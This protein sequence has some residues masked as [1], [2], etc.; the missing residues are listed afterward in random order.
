MNNKIIK[1]SL[2]FILFSTGCSNEKILEKENND[3]VNFP[4]DFYDIALNSVSGQPIVLTLKDATFLCSNEKG[5][6]EFNNNVNTIKV[7]SEETFYYCPIYKNNDENV[8]V[9]EDS[10]I[11]IIIYSESNIIGYSIIKINYIEQFTWTPQLIKASL[12]V[13]TTINEEQVENIIKGYHD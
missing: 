9:L 12:F 11:D 6:F 1:M 13:D 5:S 4:I 3:I 2:I 8:K 7:N 10:F